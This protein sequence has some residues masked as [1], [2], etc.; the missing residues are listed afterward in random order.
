VLFRS[1]HKS[2]SKLIKDFQA[3]VEPSTPEE[4]ERL[5]SA[6][7]EM[8]SAKLMKS[9]KKGSDPASVFAEAVSKV[10]ASKPETVVT[11]PIV[12]LKQNRSIPAVKTKSKPDRVV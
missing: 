5:R 1:S 11:E 4:K 8:A 9:S 10:K 7:I 3:G 2:T 6:L 12:T